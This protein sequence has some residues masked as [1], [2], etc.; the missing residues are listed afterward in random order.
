[1]KYKMQVINMAAEAQALSTVSLEKEIIANNKTSPNLLLATQLLMKSNARW[2]D[3][4]EPSHWVAWYTLKFLGDKMS[5][6]SGELVDHRVPAVKNSSKQ[7]KVDA[8]VKAI[9]M[10]EFQ[11]VTSNASDKKRSVCWSKSDHQTMM[12]FS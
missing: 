11:A 2:F 10:V 7:K 5:S 8:A 3:S 6:D 9:V 4:S 12:Y 1:M